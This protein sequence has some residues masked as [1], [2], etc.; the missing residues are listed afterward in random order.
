MY[1]NKLIKL[2][3]M[4]KM[5]GDPTRLKII[6]ALL[7]KEISVNTICKKLNMSQSAISHQLQLLKANNIVIA[8]R[9]GQ[10]INYKIAN[11]EIKN[12]LEYNAN[13]FSKRDKA[14]IIFPT[15]V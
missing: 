11:D 12:M 3:I 14:G 8:R 15:D 5:F 7:E 1:K 13:M 9:I 6:N 2:S 4:Y 10:V